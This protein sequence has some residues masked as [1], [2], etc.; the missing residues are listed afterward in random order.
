MKYIFKSLLITTL[1]T[2]PTTVSAAACKDSE[3]STQ[4]TSVP[5]SETAIK[6]NF[7]NETIGELLKKGAELIHSENLGYREL[8]ELYAILSTRPDVNRS[9]LD[10]AA[11]D[12]RYL[13]F[14]HPAESSECTELHNAAADLYEKLLTLPNL[15]Q[16]IVESVV[17]SLISMGFH[18]RAAALREQHN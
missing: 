13:G 7:R 15:T 9:D 16:D 10:R 5:S 14:R 3:L 17:E 8:I 6:D 18:E 4:H 12:L 11:W 2:L 1:L